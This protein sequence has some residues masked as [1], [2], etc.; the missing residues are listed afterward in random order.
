M[1]LMHASLIAQANG[2]VHV[3]CISAMLAESVMLCITQGLKTSQTNVHQGTLQ[4]ICWWSSKAAAPLISCIATH[5]PVSAVGEYCKC[6][7]QSTPEGSRILFPSSLLVQRHSW[8]GAHSVEQSGWPC[9][10]SAAASP[11]S[12]NYSSCLSRSTASCM[13]AQQS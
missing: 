5:A 12:G 11:G 13:Q 7:Q 1:L 9:L 4:K 2:S 8:W 10:P 3:V 6:L